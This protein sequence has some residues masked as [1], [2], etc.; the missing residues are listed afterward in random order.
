MAEV[1][2]TQEAVEDLEAIGNFYERTAPAYAASLIERLYGSVA[3]LK[4]HTHLG[5]KVPEI[6]H[7]SIRELVVERYRVIYRLAQDRVEIIVVLHGRQ[8]LVK[9]FQERK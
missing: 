9:K 2:W 8:D 3:I 4:N 5:R 1:V 6:D 7:D